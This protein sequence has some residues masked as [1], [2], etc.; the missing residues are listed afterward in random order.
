MIALSKPR[1]NCVCV[2]VF[3]VVASN[4]LFKV[5]SYRSAFKLIINIPFLSVWMFR[6]HK[7]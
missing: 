7:A 5:W 2:R 1:E 6:F 4:G 3:G